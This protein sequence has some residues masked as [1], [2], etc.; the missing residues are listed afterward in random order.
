LLFNPAVWIIDIFRL[1][2]NT[3]IWVSI[4]E[5]FFIGLVCVLISIY[6]AKKCLILKKIVCI[7]FIR[8]I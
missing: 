5:V 4:Q 7:K 3:S 6:S 1:V 2:S 8:T